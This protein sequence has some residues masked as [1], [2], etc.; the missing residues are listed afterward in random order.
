MDKLFVGM[1]VAKDW[2]DI[3]IAGCGEVKRIG[4]RAEAHRR[5]AERSRQ[6]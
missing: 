2:I 6:G 3:A 4:N 5:V 1:D